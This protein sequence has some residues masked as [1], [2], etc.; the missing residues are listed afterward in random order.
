MTLEIVQGICNLLSRWIIGQIDL[1]ADAMKGDTTIKVSSTRHYFADDPIRIF[2]FGDP[3]DISTFHSVKC[4]IDS[5]T[6]VL[7]EPLQQDYLA[8][9]TRIAKTLI[10]RIYEGD[11]PVK[12]MS[13]SIAVTMPHVHQEPFTLESVS[14]DHTV[15]IVCY[16]EGKGYQDSFRRI[17]R[18]TKRVR[19]AILLGPL[20]IE[21]FGLT[22]LKEDASPTDKTIIVESSDQVCRLGFVHFDNGKWFRTN[23]L[24]ENLGNGVFQLATPIGR[25]F[26]A[27]TD[28]M[29]PHVFPYDIRITDTQFAP[30]NT[31]QVLRKR[32][33]L[34]MSVKVEQ[35]RAKSNVRG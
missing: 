6:L 22:A 11:P 15:S 3:D 34:T 10:N 14:D 9:C 35:R 23:R 13:N 19:D 5:T 1:R 18:I 29:L 4:V 31:D 32:S 24:I 26:E 7:H 33:E 30:Q 27:G 28:V 16:A 8:D 17:H 12:P 20:F 25:A 2:I 21:P